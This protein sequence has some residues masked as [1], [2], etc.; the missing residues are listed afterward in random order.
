ME[1]S[2]VQDESSL[3]FRALPAAAI[4]GRGLGERVRGS[5]IMLAGLVEALR[6]LDQDRPAAILGTGGY[7]CVPLFVAAR[8]RRVPTLIYLPDVV[9]GVAVK[10]LA[11]IATQVACNVEASRRYLPQA[12]HAAYP[13]L[14]V[15]YP[16]TDALY[17]LDRAQSRAAFGL[18]AAG[19]ADAELPVLLVYGGSLGARSINRAVQALLP[20]ILAHAHVIHICGREGDE[21]WLRE[22]AARLAPQL[23]ARYHLYPYLKRSGAPTMLHA[24]GAADLALCRSGASTLAELPAAALPAILV[25]YPYVHQ[26]D[27]A[28]YLVQHGAAIK[29]R[30]QEL[31]SDST[32][33]RS[34]HLWQA[35]SQLLCDPQ[36]RQRMAHHSRAL[37]TPAAADTLAQALISLAIGER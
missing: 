30:D 6:L 24:F 31:L 37:A 28:D 14:V 15:G 33:A 1:Q 22:T 21:Q 7:V 29:V 25:P 27:N 17:Q 10:A 11:Q 34:G 20:D 23:Q 2:I 36:A 12:R 9:P 16:V 5:A 3:R 32:D 4:R 8:L 26:E 18:P 13:L 35:L 19:Q